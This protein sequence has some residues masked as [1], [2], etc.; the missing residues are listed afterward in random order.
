MVG[1]MRVGARGGLGLA[2]PSS[3]MEDRCLSEKGHSESSAESC[4]PQTHIFFL[5]YIA[6]T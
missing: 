4:G 3:R 6:R 5:A 2:S 1:E